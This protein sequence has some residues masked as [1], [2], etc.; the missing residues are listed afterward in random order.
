MAEHQLI[1]ENTKTALA[2]FQ[3]PT[4][5][6][7]A[8]KRRRAAPHVAGVGQRLWNGRHLEKEAHQL[9]HHPLRRGARSRARPVRPPP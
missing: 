8:A 2:V 3:K 7:L 1:P 5:V 4:L 6:T 9:A